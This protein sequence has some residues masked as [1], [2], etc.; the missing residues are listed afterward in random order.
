MN[1]RGVGDRVFLLGEQVGFQTAI[2]RLC[3]GWGE[4]GRGSVDVS[5]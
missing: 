4:K 2:C 1:A 3:P 5:L